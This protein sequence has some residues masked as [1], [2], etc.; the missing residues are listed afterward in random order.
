MA[1]DMALMLPLLEIAGFR[2]II[3]NEIPVYWYRVPVGDNRLNDRTL[4]RM[5][6]KEI[7]SKLPFKLVFLPF[8]YRLYF[9]GITFV[10]RIYR[11]I[12]RFLTHKS[13]P[14]EIRSE[15]EN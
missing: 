4:Q 12:K 14:V 2:N 1:A 5:A 6:N 15:H 13:N 3:F 11:C 9:N 7:R 8:Q 10:R